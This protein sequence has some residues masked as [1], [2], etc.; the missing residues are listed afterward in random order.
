MKSYR[1]GPS[2]DEH[3]GNTMKERQEPTPKKN[4]GMERKQEPLSIS[5][6][7]AT[8]AQSGAA[9]HHLSRAAVTA[10][11]KQCALPTDS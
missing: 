1:N 9:L 7:A 3:V 4:Y 6:A 5:A 10:T 8:Q 11:S 2:A